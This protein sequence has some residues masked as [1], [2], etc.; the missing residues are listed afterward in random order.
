MRGGQGDSTKETRQAWPERR[1]MEEEFLR[2]QKVA[3]CLIL[4][5]GQRGKDQKRLSDPATR[6][7]C[8]CWLG[9][10]WVEICRREMGGRWLRS[11]GMKEKVAQGQ[12]FRTRGFKKEESGTSLVVQWLR[13]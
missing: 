3:P 10:V 7:Q 8:R 2:R 12:S 9:A 13:I 1:R 11:G 6:R 5:Q 4:G